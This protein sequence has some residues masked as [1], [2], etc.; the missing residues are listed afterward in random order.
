[1][2]AD[3]FSKCTHELCLTSHF[4][5]ASRPVDRRGGSDRMSWDFLLLCLFYT[6][7]FEIL[8]RKPIRC[9]INCAQFRGSYGLRPHLLLVNYSSEQCAL[10]S[11]AYRLRK[12]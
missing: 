9:W 3:G 4:I 5:D 1:M 10:I 2:T 8:T 11:L 7:V 12:V 6:A